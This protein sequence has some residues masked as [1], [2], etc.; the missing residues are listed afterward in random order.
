MLSNFSRFAAIALLCVSCG[1][2]APG[3]A[4]K[5]YDPG[6]SDTEI[7]IG[8][9][10][11]YSG[12]VSSYGTIGK[13]EA[14]YFKK[15]NEEGGINGRKINFISYDDANSPPKTVEQTRKLVE[16]DEVLFVF[17]AIGTGPN[18][19]VQK[20]LNAKR[21]PQL[22]VGSGAAKW[23]KPE[24]FPWT[25]GL[26]PTYQSE[27][28]VFAKHILEH[29]P[30]A[31]IA[32]L[33]QNEDFGKDYVKGLRDG[34]GSRA[35]SMI[36]AEK[37]YEVTDPTVDS[38]IVALKASGANV[39]MSFV[40]PK[41][42][43]QA[44]RKMG[45][46]GWSPVHFLAGISNSVGSVI[47]PA[48][49][50]TAQGIISSAYMKDPTD[51]AWAE[52]APIREWIAFMERYYPE[53]DKTNSLNVYGYLAAQTVVQVLRNCGEDISRVNIM[54]EAANLK[55]FELGLLLPGIKINTSRT[56]YYPIEQLQTMRFEGQGW[57]RFGP[58]MVGEI[59]SGQSQ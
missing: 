22:F 52:D 5:K 2:A 46:I 37:T 9:T 12:P 38:Q 49:F 1:I 33:S 39:M 42:A 48:G 55:E 25:I 16:S 54:K 8:N 11:A 41:A 56:D 28:R 59:G 51:A 58:V 32:V 27:G 35:D 31:K 57:H 26:Q 44:I 3:Q 40:T 14:A 7:K 13:V 23:G 43:S 50:E 45:E 10:V 19:A 47:K 30:N 53:G 18:G 36:V 34:L 4:Q 15:I 6:A 21:I 29:Y 17:S 24:S 20:Y